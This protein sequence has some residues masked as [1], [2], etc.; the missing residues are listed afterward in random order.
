[1]RDFLEEL[2]SDKA[3]GDPIRQAQILSKPQ[4]P[5]RFYEN[6]AVANKDGGFAIFLDNKPVKTPAR[7]NLVLP[8]KQLADI[9]ADEFNR[10]K[11]NIDPATMP[12]TRLVNAIIDNVG[13]NMAA[14]CDDI[15]KF[16]GS[17]LLFYRADAPKELVERQKVNW[18]PVL[19]WVRENYGARF[20]LTQGVMFVE[21]P[22]N[23][24]EIIRS[25]LQ[26]IK[27]P[28]VLAALHSITTLCGSVLLALA[29]WQ[30]HLSLQDGW[31]LAHLDEDW[32]IEHWGED[33]EAAQKQN[34]HKAEYEAALAILATFDK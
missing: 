33:K 10:Q 23:S 28:Y 19:D 17:D 13:H 11:Q 5:K 32:T 31:Q 22:N 21:Q 34:Y 26:N 20:I 3:D 8:N 15:V 2:D 18:D 24:I 6:A 4:L 25:Q 29:V 7:N 12:A 16:A 27:S 1:M 9:V 14:V 30:G